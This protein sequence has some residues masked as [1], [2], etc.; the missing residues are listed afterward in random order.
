MLFFGGEDPDPSFDQLKSI[1]NLVASSLRQWLAQKE[2]NEALDRL[3]QIASRVP[4]AVYQYKL[5]PDGSSCFPYASE[6]INQIYRVTPEEVR[7]DASKV[8][9][10]IH[11]DDYDGVAAS[12]Q[13]SAKELSL[14]KY[15][16]RVK[17]EDGT[18][19]WL[20]GN[21]SPH[22]ELDGSVLWHGFITDITDRKKAELELAQSRSLLNNIIEHSPNSLWISDEKG[23]LIRLNQACR[24]ILLLR[25]DEVVGKYNIFKDN[26]IEEC[27][28]M[29]LVKDVFEK[30][31]T[32][33]FV[34][35]YDTSKVNNVQLEHTKKL[36]LD[37]NISPILDSK[38]RVIHAI[39]QHTDITELKKTE[40]ALTLSETK[41]KH[42]NTELQRVNTEKDKFFSIIA[43]DL[44]SPFNGFLG[45]T[46]I[47][48]T[49]LSDLTMEEVRD[50][51][52]LLNKSANG[53]FTLL[54]NLLEWSKM[55]RGL[56]DFMPV[57]IPLRSAIAESLVLT[58]DAAH[59][60]GISLEID[61]PTDLVAFADLYMFE[62]IIRNLTGNAVK[63]TPK[64]GKILIDARIADDNTIEFSI[65]DT[66]IGMN[67]EMVDNLFRLDM[68]TRRPGTEGESSNG[69]GLII[70]K[71]F[72]ER[73]GGTLWVESEDDAGSTI[74][75]N[76]P[77]KNL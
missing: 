29:P 38:E 77:N 58:I 72:I 40:A 1:T 49:E 34:I 68:N 69:L 47:M 53:L 63:F 57:S 52:Q 73:H 62:S 17:F 56:I 6:R 33:G 67:M 64:G 25:D 20:L 71:D 8:F 21:A 50:I 9:A 76:L 16:Y 15:E 46:E 26:V 19:R 65:I 12:I 22:P 4:G 45:L 42:K 13:A 2:R 11:P 48:T 41:L 23:T 55:Q 70:C 74:R 44:R 39:I 37:V 31:K 7:E 60:K 27:G 36:V 18:V 51:S 30:G 54:G 35:N 3:R 59:N 28:F 43:H 24:D 14:W 5:R 10:N 75:F 32:V 66:G 61:V